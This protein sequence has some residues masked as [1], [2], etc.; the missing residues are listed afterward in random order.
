M[1]FLNVMHD[2]VEYLVVGE[3][4]YKC[5]FCEYAAAQKTSLRYHLERH[6]KDKQLVDG[7]AEAK[8][9]GRSQETQEALRTA[10]NAHTKN[11]KRFLDGAKDVKGSLPAKQLKETPSVFQSVL[12]PAHK[13]TQDFHKNAADDGEKVRRSPAPA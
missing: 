1:P 9:E 4:P 3:K 2:T 13:D 8:S 6:H 10:D 11:L 7:A 5:E 12:S